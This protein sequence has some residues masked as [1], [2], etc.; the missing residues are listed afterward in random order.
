MVLQ[1]I[2]LPTEL[3]RRDH[4]FSRKVASES[5]VCS[6]NGLDHHVDETAIV[7]AIRARVRR[8]HCSPRVGVT[9]KPLFFLDRVSGRSPS[10]YDRVSQQARLARRDTSLQFE[11]P[12]AGQSLTVLSAFCASSDL[13][14]IRP[15]VAVRRRWCVDQL[16]TAEGNF[17]TPEENATV[18]AVRARMR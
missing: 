7:S 8:D 18:H 16:K 15:I 1:T 9:P 14:A 2:A 5:N 3:P 13:H 12:G 10:D 6:R 11:I 17:T 4:H